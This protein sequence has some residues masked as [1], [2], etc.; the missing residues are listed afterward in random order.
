[1]NVPPPVFLTVI[2]LECKGPFV[3]MGE[4]AKTEYD[5]TGE[6]FCQRCGAYR[7]CQRGEKR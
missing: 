3:L 7:Q 6:A 4:V 1:M 2:C 5:K